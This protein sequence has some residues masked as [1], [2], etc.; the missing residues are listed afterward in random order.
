MTAASFAY[1]TKSSYTVRIRSTD[2]GGLE[3]RKS[4]SRSA[5]SPTC[6]RRSAAPLADPLQTPTSSSKP[7]L[8]SPARSPTTSASASASLTYITG[9]GTGTQSTA[10]H[11]DVREHGRSS[12]GRAARAANNTWTVTGNYCELA[13]NCNYDTLERQHLRA[14]VQGTGDRQHLDRRHDRHRQRHQ[15][16]R[17]VGLRAV[18]SSKN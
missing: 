7:S 6:R 10:V 5:S 11:R 12:P 4:S 2:Q 15:C 14:D 13:T 3:Y 18:L 16:R 9:S 17:G 1:A 8:R